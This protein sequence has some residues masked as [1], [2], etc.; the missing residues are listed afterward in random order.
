VHIDSIC[1]TDIK[2]NVLVDWQLI[3]L[4]SIISTYSGL[5]SGLPPQWTLSTMKSQH[6]NGRDNSGTLYR[7]VLGEMAF[8]YDN[9]YILQQGGS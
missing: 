2:L 4:Y 6:K 7:E 1:G 3:Y 9:V 8:S 5:G